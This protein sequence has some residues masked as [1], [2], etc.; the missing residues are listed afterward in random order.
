MRLETGTANLIKYLKSWRISSIEKT[1]FEIE[2]TI[3]F[4]DPTSSKK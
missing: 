4:V 1:V 3:I 2:N